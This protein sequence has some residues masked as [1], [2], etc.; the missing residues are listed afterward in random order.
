ML[1][2][3]ISL[4][5]LSI[6]SLCS[7]RIP[8]RLFLLYWCWI[9]YFKAIWAGNLLW[10]CMCLFGALR[11]SSSGHGIHIQFTRLILFQCVYVSVSVSNRAEFLRKLRE[12]SLQMLKSHHSS[13][14]KTCS[15]RTADNLFLFN[16][17]YT[18]YPK[19]LS[20][21]MHQC[22][23]REIPVSTRVW[24]IVSC[25]FFVHIIFHTNHMHTH[26]LFVFWALNLN[27]FSW[28]LILFV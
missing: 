18:K 16:Y 28:L 6:D 26:S 25:L 2:P 24:C 11:W 21:I 14:N 17:S 27:W 10:N 19:L 23:S 1:V 4:F 8:R 22:C 3:F 9:I 5:P 7:L 13:P 12:N 15:L 20:V